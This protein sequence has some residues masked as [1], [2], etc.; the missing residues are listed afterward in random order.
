MHLSERWDSTA[1][2]DQLICA[3]LTPA[4]WLYALGWQTY[5][6]T[7]RLGLKQAKEPHKPVLVIGNL[8]SGGSGKS[9]M[10][11]H[12]AHILQNMGREVV[13]SCSGYGSPSS[14][15]A[16]LAP[17]GPLD[18]RQWGDEPA[19]L[20]WLEPTL[21]LIVGRRRVLAAQL[22]HQHHPNAV[23]LM[24]DGFQHLPL[25]KHISLVLDNPNPKN[26]RCLPAGPY[27]EPRQ[28]R[29]RADLVLPNKAFEIVTEPL[30]LETPDGQTKQPKKAAVLCALGQPQNF[31]YALQKTGLQV[32]YT[33][34]RPDHDPLDAGN[35]FESIPA[36]QP[37]VVTAKDWVKLRQRPDIGQR[38]VLIA[39]HEVRVEPKEEFRAW[40]E[41]KL[42]EF[43]I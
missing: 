8:V 30:L 4:S 5:L 14:E 15:A 26:K 10:T 37:V 42:N 21:P 3:L 22:A 20:R 35:L 34:L 24:D 41:S 28:N 13:V 18:P 38:E 27:R 43:K 39:K 31:L 23:L 36:S 29:K 25:K 11:R 16:Q 32:T 12:I 1:P 19:M 9:P 40:L 7:Y 2:T 6:A 17:D 33:T